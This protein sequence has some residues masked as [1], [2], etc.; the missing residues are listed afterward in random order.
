MPI[1]TTKEAADVLDYTDRNEMP[2]KVTTVFLPA[3]DRFIRDATGKDWGT[4]T[5]GYTQVDPTAKMVAGV[6][7]ARWFGDPGLIGKVNDS[8]VLS[9][10]TQ[11]EA[12]ALLERQTG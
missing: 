2:E 6:L 10:I 7:L 12:K 11:L 3:V 1:L 5:D 9:L 4:I 8:G